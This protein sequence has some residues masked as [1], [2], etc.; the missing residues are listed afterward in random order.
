M[1]NHP[2]STIKVEKVKVQ[3]GVTM[4]VAKPSQ[5]PDKAQTPTNTTDKK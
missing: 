3:G 2:Q 5:E 1:N 4:P